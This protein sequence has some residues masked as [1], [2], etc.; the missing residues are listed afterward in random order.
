MCGWTL[1]KL[2][3]GKEE[4]K[5]NQNKILAIFKNKDKEFVLHKHKQTPK[6]SEEITFFELLLMEKLNNFRD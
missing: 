4:I 3:N 6:A 2:Y 1:T 5:G